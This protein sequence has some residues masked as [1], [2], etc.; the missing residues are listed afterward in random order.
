MSCIMNKSLLVFRLLPG[1]DLFNSI[2]NKVE[3]QA[4]GSRSF[5]IV[6]C[7]GSLNQCKIRLAGAT[8][9]N[10]ATKI[11]PGPLEIVSLVGTIASNKAHIHISVSDKEGLTYGGHLMAGST[12]DTTAEIV[13]A[14]LESLAGVTITREMDHQTGFRELCV[15]P[16]TTA[17]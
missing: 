8:A 10:Q 3:S 14:N 13:L 4:E 1:D 17:K 5:A 2:L 6:T 9:S 11:I 12:I 7:V 15:N 16:L